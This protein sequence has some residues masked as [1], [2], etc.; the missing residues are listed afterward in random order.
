MVFEKYISRDLS[1]SES[2]AYKVYTSHIHGVWL[3]IYTIGCIY[4]VYFNLI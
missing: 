3:V 4:Q 2:Y 1:T